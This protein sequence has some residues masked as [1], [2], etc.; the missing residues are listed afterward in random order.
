MPNISIPFIQGQNESVD[1][2]MLPL[3]ALL[4]VRNAR[5]RKDNRWGSR[6]AYVFNSSAPAQAIAAGNFGPKRSVYIGAR[7]SASV[8]AKW[9]DRREDGVF[10]TP[11]AGSCP[12]DLG[13]PRRL[14]LIRNLKYSCLACDVVQAGS[15]IFAVYQDASYT[16]GTIN[17]VT[18]VIHEALGG[19]L[20]SRNLIGGSSASNPKITVVGS[21]VMVF[22]A[23]ASDAIKYF[24]VDSVALSTTTGTCV[25]AATG[26]AFSFDIAP[27]SGSSCLLTYEQA[28]NNIRTGLVNT[29]GAF[30]TI[31]NQATTNPSRMSVCLGSSGNIA[32]VWNEGATFITGNTYYRVDTIVGVSVVAK[33]SLDSSGS[34]V[35]F[36]V[37]GTNTTDDY[38]FSW[39]DGS[40]I[41]IFTKGKSN[42]LIGMV[43]AVSKPFMGPNNACLMWVSNFADGG[44]TSGVS[45][46]TGQFAT[47]KLVDVESPNTLPAAQG[48]TCEAIA[49]QKV[50]MPGAYL[51]KSSTYQSYVD[52]RRFCVTVPTV[53]S[54]PGTTAFATV[55][56][57]LIAGG[58]GADLI[59]MDNGTYVDR[60]LPASIN[61]QLLFSGPRVREFDG[62]NLVETGLADGPETCVL[63]DAAAGTLSAGDYQYVL[64]Y[65]WQDA[66]GRRHR[67]PP[68]LPIKIT[69]GASRQTTV[70]Y[71]KPAFSDKAG[72]NGSDC[73]IYL[74][75]WRTLANGTVFY[76]VNSTQH[77]TM[78]ALGGGFTSFADNNSDTSISTNEVLYTQGAR[79][80]LSGLL[81]NDE[82]PPC[83]YIWSGNNRVIMGGLEQP[84]MVQWSKL[85]FPGEPM[86]FSTS[87]AFQ[88]SVDG[89]VTGV[90]ALDGTWIVF[91]RDSIWA[92]T[93]DGPDDSGNGFFNDPRKIPS[94]VGC[95]SQRSIVEIP[96]GLV[97]HARDGKLYLLPR[98]GNA[99]V[100]FGQPMRDT[101]S[102]S[103]IVAAKLLPEE[104]LLAFLCNDNSGTFS[105][106]MLRDMRTGAWS[107]DYNTN[108]FTAA[109]RKSLDIYNGALVLD[110]RIFETTTSF[111][112]NVDGSTPQSFTMVLRTGDVRP[113]G[114]SGSGRCRRASVLGEVR[115]VGTMQYQIQVSYDSGLSF[116]DASQVYSLSTVAGAALEFDHDLVAPRGNS[117][118]F[119]I[120]A[121]PASSSAGLEGAV[122]NSLDLEVFPERSTKRLPATARLG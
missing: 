83:R 4:E 9:W 20:I 87:S 22:W 6:Y 5:L 66:G 46:Q 103:F 45:S 40:D 107:Y 33:T 115:S 32:L 71:S 114:P 55:L 69:L 50:A 16:A 113:F 116:S 112:D 109:G 7:T 74:M 64:T 65:E 15:Y 62:T 104:N 59:R 21:I 119:L 36:P 93:G 79:G 3:G 27:N 70:T 80:G 85:V 105:F 48:I 12:G 56:P 37:A 51:N 30:T 8:P 38:T 101:F 75:I 14:P 108:V 94:E 84:N 29:A 24:T 73:G 96:E 63:A 54:Q 99:P 95:V 67:S 57:I 34:V 42:K 47:Y 98:G 2:K 72:G 88:A 1:P 44:E 10:T 60:L 18:L 58:F 110:G 68:S 26:R 53:L 117:F 90:A 111:T 81:Q 86:Q 120:A 76:L 31:T 25:T 106:M 91:T 82:P 41:T 102:N 89:E 77:I 122:I 49:G 23:D 11:A 43:A 118:R 13:V 97:F 39:S 121:A 61:G 78:G 35:G 52:P 17:G 92:I 100:F 28:A 19:R